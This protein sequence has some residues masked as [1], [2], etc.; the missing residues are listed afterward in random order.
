M[1]LSSGDAGVPAGDHVFSAQRWSF[2]GLKSDQLLAFRAM[3]LGKGKPLSAADSELL[4]TTASRAGKPLTNAANLLPK[5]EIIG[6]AFAVC[7]EALSNAFGER[8]LD[9]EAENK[10]RC[11]Q[12][13]TSAEKLARRRIGGFQERIARFRTK[14]NIR[15]IA[16]TEGLIRKEDEQLKMKLDRIARKERVD[17]TMIP[18]A[19]GV[20]RVE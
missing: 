8:L 14:G 20:I 6:E 4:V 9:F 3:R 10:V 18:L 12:Q 7:E 17:P 11:D 5:T 2:S 1:K 16:M 15:L 19:V 13:K